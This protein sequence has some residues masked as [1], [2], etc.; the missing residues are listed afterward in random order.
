MGQKKDLF[1]ISRCSNAVALVAD[2][3]LYIDILPS[4]LYNGNRLLAQSRTT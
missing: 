2:S 3:K 1:P 4:P